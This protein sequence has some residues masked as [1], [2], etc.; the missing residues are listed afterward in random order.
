MSCTDF[1]EREN[2]TFG[3]DRKSIV[4]ENNLVQFCRWETKKQRTKGLSRV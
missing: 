2:F 4:S 3:H 1:M